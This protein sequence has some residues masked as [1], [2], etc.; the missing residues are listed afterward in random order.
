MRGGG[1]VERGTRTGSHPVTQR[2][3]IAALS[4]LLSKS[5]LD[6]FVQYLHVATILPFK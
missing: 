5:L 4:L 6:R 2:H 1:V 3:K